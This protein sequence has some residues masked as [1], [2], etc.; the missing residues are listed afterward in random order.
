L[1]QLAIKPEKVEDNQFS[2]R[3]ANGSRIVALPSKE[4]TVRGFSGVSLGQNLYTPDNIFTSQPIYND[5]P[6]AASS[7]LSVAINKLFG[8]AL[9]GR[10]KERP[11][12][13]DTPIRLEAHL[14][15]VPRGGDGLVAR[16]FEP[17]GYEVNVAPLPLDPA[18]LGE[19]WY[20]DLRLGA[21]LRLS[22]LLRHLYVLLP[23]LD[24]DKHYWVSHDEIEKLLDRGGDWLAEHPE[25]ELIT[26]RY[27]RHQGR[28]A[29]EAL[30]R[31]GAVHVLTIAMASPVF[32]FNFFK[33]FCVR[34]SPGGSDHS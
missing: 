27:L 30:A 2:L 25:R 18:E 23:V 15:V 13:A 11:E 16:L 28:L 17:L 14:P 20:V 7:F 5:R 31:G 3:L 4:A 33:L 24:D 34:L 6:Y 8:T 32:H 1:N 10:S 19:S 22:D 29:R 12:L 9:T 21:T 26:A